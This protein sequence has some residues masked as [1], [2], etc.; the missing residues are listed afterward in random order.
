M[1]A[2]LDKRTIS[3]TEALRRRRRSVEERGGG[4]GSVESHHRLPLARWRSVMHLAGEDAK[5]FAKM[6]L[7]GGGVCGGEGQGFQSKVSEKRRK[8]VGGR[9]RVEGLKK[10]NKETV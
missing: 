9:K 7:C 4:W 1:S 6:P 2:V 10:V 5:L 8:I 3:V